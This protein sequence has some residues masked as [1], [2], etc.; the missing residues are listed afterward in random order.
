MEAEMKIR[1]IAPITTLGIACATETQQ[2]GDVE[3]T[4]TTIATGPASI[5]SEYEVAFSL[6]GTITA[7]LDAE[8]EG[9]DAIVINCMCDPGLAGAREA[10]G[11]PVVGAAQAAFHV[12]AM[13][14][15]S[16]SV[17]VVEA[18]EIP[19]YENNAKL[20]GLDSKLRSIRSIDIPVLDLAADLDRVV[21]ALYAESVA[22]IEHDG[23]HALV[24]GCTGMQDCDERLRSRLRDG[25]YADVPVVEPVAAAIALARALVDLRLTQSKRTYPLPPAKALVG[26][27]VGTMR[28]PT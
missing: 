10:L 13:L 25:G 24:L 20:Y 21:E 17:L 22:A 14:A 1:V 4:H 7:A 27:G 28:A 12:A 23:A 5:E 9:A 3:V 6:P 15:H 16:F 19:M 11:V 2:A 8:A 18:R 26:Y